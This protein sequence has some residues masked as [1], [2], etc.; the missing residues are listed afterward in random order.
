MRKIYQFF[1][2]M[3]VLVLFLEILIGFPIHLE[4]LPEIY[5]TSKESPISSPGAKQKMEGVHLVESRQG[6]RDWE[7]FAETA[8]GYEGKGAWELQHVKVLF[9]NG[10]AIDYTVLGKI[11]W[12]DTKT[13]DM[14]IE[15][16]VVTTSNNGYNF[17]SQLIEYQASKRLLVSPD[18]VKMTAPPEGKESHGMIVLGSGM[19]TDIEQ[20]IMKINKDVFATKTLASG[21]NFI[22]K[23]ERAN[24]SGK[25][26]KVSFFDRVSIQVD[27]LKLEGP[28][29]QFEYTTGV[30]F[31]NSI[32][33]KGGVRV[34]DIDKYAT[35]D[36]VRFETNEN[37]FV[38]NGKPRVV[39]NNDEMTG[40]KIIF[41]DGGKRIKVDNIKAR[42]DEK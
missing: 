29:A 16:D 18:K 19:E 30:N 3:F 13:K 36:Q 31:L 38:F 28:E 10:E 21:K 32:L 9:Y 17:F 23:S 26:K 20:N 8:E 6:A 1:L 34:S 35:A 12:I 22:I 41:L 14:K 11:G 27:N 39:Q 5:K 24:F 40:D 37:R 42:M 15:G 2:G 25:S 33:V 4:K 7:L